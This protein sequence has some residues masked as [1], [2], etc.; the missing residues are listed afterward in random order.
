MGQ[1]EVPGLRRFLRDYPQM[2]I[3]PS[4]DSYLRVKG[5]FAFVADHAEYGRIND[6]FELQIDV[7]HAF[8]RDLPRVIETGGKIPRT[9]AY[10]VNPDRTLCLG[11]PLSLLLRISQSP[12][13]GGF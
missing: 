3:R 6:S 9:G 13:L 11:S 12:S 4:A 8:P 10:H 1:E 7:P 2:A 5:F